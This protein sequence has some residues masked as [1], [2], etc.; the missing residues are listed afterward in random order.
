MVPKEKYQKIKVSIYNIETICKKNKV[1]LEFAHF[2]LKKDNLIKAD[3]QY[4]KII[5]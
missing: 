1:T 5:E 2:R 4:Q 3:K